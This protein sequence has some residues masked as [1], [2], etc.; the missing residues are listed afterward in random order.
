TL[1]G[2]LAV[3]KEA[4]GELITLAPAPRKFVEGILEQYIDSIPNDSDDEHSA[5]SGTGDLRIMETAI[6]KVEEIYSRALKGRVTLYEMCG[7]CPEWRA[8]EDVCKGIRELIVLLED[9]LC[10]A[11]QGTSTL[12]EAHFLDELAYQRCK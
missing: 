2:S 11:I 9:V 10:L 8:T 7:V 4:K 1:S 6:A 3:V 5:K 12:A